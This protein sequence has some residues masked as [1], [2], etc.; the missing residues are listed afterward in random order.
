M[1]AGYIHQYNSLNSHPDVLKSLYSPLQPSSS[2]EGLR[3]TFCNLFTFL[4]HF[5]TQYPCLIFKPQNLETS[6]GDYSI[7]QCMI[8]FLF[9]YAIH[10]MQPTRMKITFVNTY[11]TLDSWNVK[12]LNS[13]ISICWCYR[14][15]DGRLSDQQMALLQYQRENLHF[16][17]EEVCHNLNHP[18][19][20]DYIHF[21]WY[22]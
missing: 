19:I 1:L 21:N 7:S 3:Q 6:F 8:I 4:I 20:V 2:L 12:N 18:L 22:W 16:L 10:V 15:H 5:I 17:S 13:V 11:P 14:Y 9:M